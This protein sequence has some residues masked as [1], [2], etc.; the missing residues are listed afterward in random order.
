MLYLCGQG[1]RS[2][3]QSESWVCSCCWLRLC[4]RLLSHSRNALTMVMLDT[5]RFAADG[6]RTIMVMKVTRPTVT[7]TSSVQS[8]TSFL[9]AP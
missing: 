9:T 6:E 1:S 3:V 2:I 7:V 4:G 8:S 5:Q